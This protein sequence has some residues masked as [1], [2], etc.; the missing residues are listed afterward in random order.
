MADAEAS[1]SKGEKKKRAKKKPKAD[2][3]GAI[4][5]EKAMKLQALEEE[6]ADRAS[7]RKARPNKQSQLLA[8]RPSEDFTNKVPEPGGPYPPPRR[9]DSRCGPLG[10]PSLPLALA[11]ARPASC[12]LGSHARAHA[13]CR[14]R[15]TRRRRWR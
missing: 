15:W 2:E 13:L 4:I 11:P 8:R 7:C 3:D 12:L 1:A 9:A 5:D 14:R 6:K 10:P